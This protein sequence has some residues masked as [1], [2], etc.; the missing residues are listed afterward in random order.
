MKLKIKELVALLAFVTFATSCDDGNIHDVLHLDIN[1]GYAIR[2]KGNIKNMSQWES[3]KYQIAVAAFAVQDSY[4]LLAKSLPQTEGEID[5]RFEGINPDCETIELCVLNRIN[6]KVAS[7]ATLFNR[8]EDGNRAIEDTIYYNAGELDAG[9]YATIQASIFNKRCAFCHG[10]GETPAAGLY[11]TDGNS[12]ESLVNVPSKKVDS[13]MRVEPNHAERST[14]YKVLTEYNE[15][16]AWH[17]DHTKF[18][19]GNSM[20]NLVKEWISQGAIK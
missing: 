11:L 15:Y 4:P 2:L 20:S 12:F 19:Y 10:M 7:L 13:L 14:L 16:S 9:M 8:G 18:F 5:F 6:K 17:Y 3:G 1:E